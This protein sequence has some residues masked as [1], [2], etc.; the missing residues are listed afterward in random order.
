[1]DEEL[2][3]KLIKL[4]FF[5]FILFLYKQYNNIKFFVLNLT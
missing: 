3:I 5:D 1:M 2:L 4:S